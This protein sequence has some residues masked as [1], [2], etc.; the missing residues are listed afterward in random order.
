[1]HQNGTLPWNEFV[2]AV[3][4]V[5]EKRMGQPTYRRII[6]DKP[7]EEDYFYANPHECLCEGTKCVDLLGP[8]NSSQ[9]R[10]VQVVECRKYALLAQLYV[11]K[12]N[13][14]MA[15]PHWHKFLEIFVYMIL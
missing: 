2:D 15:P 13:L 10:W 3:R 8:H 12:S 7:K 9:V 1:M 6:V 11:W 5:H 4:Q 14:K